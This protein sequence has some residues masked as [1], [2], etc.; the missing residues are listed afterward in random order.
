MTTDERSKAIL[1]IATL[2]DDHTRALR[3]LEEKERELANHKWW[4]EEIGTNSLPAAKV[5]VGTT[6]TLLSRAQAEL[7]GLT[8]T[9]GE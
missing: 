1:R 5:E 4:L 3:K 9:I 7:A 2:A 6:F 8:A